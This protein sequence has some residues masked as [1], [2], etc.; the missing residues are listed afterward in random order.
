MAWCRQAASHYLSQCW[1]FSL[2]V[3]VTVEIC[4]PIVYLNDCGPLWLLILL[5]VT[6]LL[7]F[8]RIAVT[9]KCFSFTDLQKKVSLILTVLSI[10]QS[11][12]WFIFIFRTSCKTTVKSNL[13]SVVVCTRT[14]YRQS[15][16]SNQ[17]QPRRRRWVRRN[18]RLKSRV[19]SVRYNVWHVSVAVLWRKT[20]RKVNISR[21]S[22]DNKIDDH[23]DVVG[24]SPVGAAP[25]TSSFST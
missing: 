19:D 22:V 14:S 3:Y 16:K 5:P 4:L 1:L 11:F 23:S 25:T 15:Q 17:W 18:R 24:A 8:S 21:T 12:T 7:T 2:S 20:Y 6:C 13:W 9:N 10:C